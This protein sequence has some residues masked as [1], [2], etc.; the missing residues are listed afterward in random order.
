MGLHWQSWHK[1]SIQVQKQNELEKLFVAMQ[2]NNR[3]CRYC[4][5][6]AQFESQRRGKLAME[7]KLRRARR[8]LFYNG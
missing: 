4:R 3:L 2:I 5:S 6:I 8:K 1:D 7:L